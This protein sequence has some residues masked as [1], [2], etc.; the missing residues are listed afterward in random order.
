MGVRFFLKIFFFFMWTIFKVFIAF[1]TKLL[2]FY[3]LG[4]WPWGMWSLSSPTRDRTRT[5]CIGRQSLNH[6][7]TREVPHMGVLRMRKG[8]CKALGS[9]S[10]MWD[11]LK[12]NWTYNKSHKQAVA[13]VWSGAQHWGGDLRGAR[14]RASSNCGGSFWVLHDP[15]D[16][17]VGV[18]REWG[19]APRRTHFLVLVHGNS[20][21][22]PWERVRAQNG[23][24]YDFSNVLFLFS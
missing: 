5:P 23:N 7:T 6:W 8:V 24:C 4:F 18:G 16:Q 1:V 15:N 22:S 12:W 2:L 9:V 20:K 14:I 13:G 19:P 21:S 17:A 10:G 3:V 11:V